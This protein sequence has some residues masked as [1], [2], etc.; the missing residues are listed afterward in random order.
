[1]AK[2]ADILDKIEMIGTGNSSV[3]LKH[4]NE[5]FT[6]HPTT[7]FINPSKNETGR[8][9]KYILDQINTK[10]VCEL[11]VNEWKNTIGLIK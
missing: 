10:L 5:N 9:S 11:S 1:M 8:I 7:R 6:S 3:T 4:H 2:R